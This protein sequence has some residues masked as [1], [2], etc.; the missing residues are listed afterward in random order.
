MQRG[1]HGGQ[2]E[3]RDEHVTIQPLDGGEPIFAVERLEVHGVVPAVRRHLDQRGLVRGGQVALAVDDALIRDLAVLHP[4]PEGPGVQ[5]RGLVAVRGR[6]ALGRQRPLMVLFLDAGRVP[7]A[8]RLELVIE[9]VEQGVADHDVADQAHA[10]AG[11]REQGHQAGDQLAAQRA[12]GQPA[13]GPVPPPDVRSA[14]SWHQ[15]PGRHPA[16]GMP[17]RRRVPAAGAPAGGGC[18]ARTTLLMLRTMPAV[19]PR[20]FS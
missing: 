15:P 19:T 2:R 18:G 3:S 6:G 9:L 14:W 7:A 20:M 13:G 5:A 11:Q 10:G 8:R 17:A 1:F 4:R 12:G 16:A